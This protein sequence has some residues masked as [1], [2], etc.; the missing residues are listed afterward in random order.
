MKPSEIG[1]ALT[2]ICDELNAASSAIEWWRLVASAVKTVTGDK[3]IRLARHVFARRSEVED[4]LM[5]LLNVEFAALD[6]DVDSMTQMW[7]DTPV[8]EHPAWIETFRTLVERGVPRTT[9]QKVA[10][11]AEA[12]DAVEL[13]TVDG[14]LIVDLFEASLGV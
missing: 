11:S 2:S 13:F 1:E 5:R 9:A 4:D 3:D 12:L 6:E 8:Q 14:V 10:A 7:D